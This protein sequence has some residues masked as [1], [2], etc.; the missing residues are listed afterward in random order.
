MASLVIVVLAILVL[1]FRLAHRYT[2][3]S[4][5]DSDERCTPATVVGVS[6]ETDTSRY[7]EVV[8]SFFN[9]LLPWSWR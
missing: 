6:N 8:G 5:T 4:R 9:R 7:V 2:Y 1:S 3:G